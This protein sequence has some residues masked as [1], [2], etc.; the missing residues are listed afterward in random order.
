MNHLR[1]LKP[2]EQ[3]QDQEEIVKRT[4]P[5]TP[6]LTSATWSTT[7]DLKHGRR[8]S[9]GQ[10]GQLASVSIRT[11]VFFFKKERPRPPELHQN[12]FR[13]ITLAMKPSAT[14][15]QAGNQRKGHRWYLGG[16]ASAG[17]AAC[18]HPLDLLKV[19]AELNYLFRVSYRSFF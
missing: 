13:E 14:T 4:V 18:T 11:H 6:H 9:T 19:S 3:L 7:F 17:A 12:I 10:L 2:A 5:Y 16:M 15:S 1:H 8:S